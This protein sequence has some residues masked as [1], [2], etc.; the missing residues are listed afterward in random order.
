[1]STKQL[2]WVEAEQI[3]ARAAEVS[4]GLDSPD[5]K[6]MT[7]KAMLRVASDAAFIALRESG[8]L[9]E[10]GR[11]DL[12]AISRGADRASAKERRWRGASHA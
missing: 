5:S 10:Q 3:A 7:R 2:G 9:D 4:L 8:L 1:M 12:A 11:R 6:V